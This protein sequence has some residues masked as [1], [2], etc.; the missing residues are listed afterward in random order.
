MG[1]DIDNLSNIYIDVLKEIGNIGAGNAATALSKMFLKPI[2]M[3]V[4]NI[5]IIKFSN[6]QEVLNVNDEIVVGVLLGFNGDISGNILYVLDKN[7]ADLAI[8]ILLGDENK[9]FP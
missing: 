2:D 3:S 1:I 8:K 5:Q 4:P 6:M 7:E 9:E